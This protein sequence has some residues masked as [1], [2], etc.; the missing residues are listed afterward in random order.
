MFDR[1]EERWIRELANNEQS[2]SVKKFLRQYGE[3]FEDQV[4][5]GDDDMSS[6]HD[7]IK[8]IRHICLVW[9]KH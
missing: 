3:P 9:G 4:Y 6:Y 7:L 5:I 1:I 8:Y 2:T